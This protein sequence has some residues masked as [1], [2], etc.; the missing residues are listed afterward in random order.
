[1]G[2]PTAGGGVCISDFLKQG[3]LLDGV[4][5]AEE[6]KSLLIDYTSSSTGVNLHEIFFP[7][8]ICI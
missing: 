1:M 8:T 7:C 6:K 5:P 2:G 4:I 3:S